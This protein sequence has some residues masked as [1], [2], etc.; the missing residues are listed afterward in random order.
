MDTTF[1]WSWAYPDND[2]VTQAAERDVRT[3]VMSY[4]MRGA[5]DIEDAASALCETHFADGEAWM[6]HWGED[7][8]TSIIIDIQEPAAFAGR[9]EVDMEKVLH[10][11]SRKLP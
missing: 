5:T 10:A 6:D 1:S 7:D 9:Y 11:R 2:P 3:K 8:S 4:R